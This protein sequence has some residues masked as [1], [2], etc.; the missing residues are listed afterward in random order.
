MLFDL[1]NAGATY[2]RSMVTLFH[3]MMHTKIE[4]YVDDMIDKS[5]KGESH[6][7][8]LKKLF[9]RLRKYKLRLNPVK[10]SFGVKSGKLPRFVVFDRGIVVDS[11]KLKA[12]QS[13][14]A[15]KIKKK[16]RGFLGR[17]NYI[18][19]FISRLTTTYEQIF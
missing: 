15:P 2:Q 8:V 17:L 12:I 10:Y 16:V 13:K 11:D 1:K 4:V 6:V 14:P 9:K 19:W 18:A 7:Q 5:K 3:D